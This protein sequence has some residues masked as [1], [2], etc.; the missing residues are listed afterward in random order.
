MNR[1][2]QVKLYTQESLCAELPFAPNHIF[3]FL[4]RLCILP[5][6]LRE[7][8]DAQTAL[9]FLRRFYTACV[10]NSR[11][12]FDLQYDYTRGDQIDWNAFA[13]NVSSKL[14]LKEDQQISS[15]Q[16]ADLETDHELVWIHFAR[17][18]VAQN[19]KFEG[20]LLFHHRHLPLECFGFTLHLLITVYD[21]VKSNPEHGFFSNLLR[22]PP[23][24]QALAPKNTE[25]PKKKRN[26]QSYKA[27]VAHGQR[28][29]KHK[30][31][32]K[33]ALSDQRQMLNLLA[34]G[35]ASALMMQNDALQ[36]RV[37]N[38]EE[39]LKCMGESQKSMEIRFMDMLKKH[40]ERLNA[41]E[42]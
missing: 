36:Q 38:L 40:E 5:H 24:L 41:L 20:E 33:T 2:A 39:Q 32:N 37:D 28:M 16:I 23:V 30:A 35:D 10:T 31:A 6:E 7:F 19:N 18:L 9:P 11:R 25:E 42:K 12:S 4:K 34:R 13:T 8:I 21:D 26:R 22:P 1:L 3:A 15:D 17:K 14:R 27:R 29:A